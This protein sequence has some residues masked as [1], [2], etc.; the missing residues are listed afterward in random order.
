MIV[1]SNPFLQRRHM[2]II[3]GLSGAWSRPLGLIN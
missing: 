1:W 3:G 2:L